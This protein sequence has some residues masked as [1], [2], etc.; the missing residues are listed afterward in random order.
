MGGAWTLRCLPAVAFAAV[1]LGLASTPVVAAVDGPCD[2]VGYQAASV[3]ARAPR[4]ELGSTPRWLV[5]RGSS[6]TVAG[7]AGQPRGAPDVEGPPS[8]V[9]VS[10]FADSRQ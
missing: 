4:M 2:A 3:N 9:P 6:L 10:P 8:R 7:P 1:A 5:G